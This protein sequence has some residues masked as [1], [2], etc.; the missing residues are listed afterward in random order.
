MTEATETISP[1]AV[2][3]PERPTGA[4]MAI[5]ALEAHGVDTVFGIPGVHT[6]ALYDALLD[7]SIR[8]VLSRHEQGAGFMADGYAR[9]SGKPGVAF[10]ITGP[11]VTNIATPIGEAYTD[12]SPVMV[13]SSNCPRPYLDGMRGNL[14]DLKDQLGVMAAVTKW[15]ARAMSADD[16]AGLIGEGFRQMGNGRPLPVH[17]EI[18]L[19]VF[20]EA[21]TS[22]AIPVSRPARMRPDPTLLREAAERLATSKRV[23][24]YCGGG[25]VHA[26]AGESIVEIAEALN[27]PIMTSFMGKGSVPED[28]PLCVGALWEEG[29]P[30][31]DLLQSADCL[32]VFG[33]KLGAQATW[34]FKMRFPAEMIRIDVDEHE[35]TLNATPTLG[36]IG[37]AGLAAEGIAALLAGRGVNAPGY[38]Q[39]DVEEART[40]AEKTS[41]HAHR[42]GYV[43]AL[44]RAIPRDG[45]ISTDMTQ[46]S[47]VG[48]YLY[49]V[50]EPRTY[51]FP[52]G[53]GTLGFSVPAAIGAKIA[54]PDKVVVPIVGD[55]G[56]QFTMGEL[57]TAVQERLGLPIVIFNDS[58]YSAV[59]EN[60]KITR[61]SRYIAV[62][63]VNPDYVDLAKAYRIPGVRAHSPEELEV[64]I[65]AALQR[66]LPTII[67]VP[68][69]PWI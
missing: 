51:M 39:S 42:R 15:N 34:M 4:Q 29:N 58:T 66:D 22:D 13:I 12:S 17:I 30:I 8:H 48:C 59:K 43:D 28:H 35:L 45:I 14:H 24:I 67:D 50:Y 49:P 2:A 68:I 5:A 36:I 6:L 64:E 55:G 37:D 65:A 52:S 57:G 46:M 56:Y 41:F 33:S 38:I 1:I 69:E 26:N 7:S 27:A 63:L 31:D 3:T 11:G 9:A 62:D 18:P 19:D 10:V 44:R 53:Y 47:Y 25:A 61:G 54:R 23:V 16:V 20:D 40:A 60:Q 32:L 21:A